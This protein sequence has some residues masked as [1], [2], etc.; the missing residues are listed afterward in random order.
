MNKIFL[1]AIVSFA[2]TGTALATHSG[3][4]TH[5]GK[6]VS[7]PTVHKSK[8]VYAPAAHVTPHGVIATAPPGSDVDVDVDGD[9]IEI[10]VSPKKRGLLGLGVGPL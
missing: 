2:L 3:N 8:G 4:E 1:A 6:T 10:D 5:N 7:V 9:D